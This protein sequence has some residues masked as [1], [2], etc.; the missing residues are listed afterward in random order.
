M[1]DITPLLAQIKMCKDDTKLL[2]LIGNLS[3]VLIE[4]NYPYV[5]RM[6]AQVKRVNDEMEGNGVV[7]LELK[8]YKGDVVEAVFHEVTKVKFN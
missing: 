6:I 2:D 3:M 4:N 7:H 5:P 8:M 1:T